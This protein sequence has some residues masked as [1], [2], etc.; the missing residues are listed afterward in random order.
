MRRLLLLAI[1][2][3]AFATMP[4]ANAEGV[5]DT[6]ICASSDNGG[7]S[8]EQRIAACTDLIEGSK[9][10][11]SPEFVAA[12]GSRCAPYWYVDKR[13]LAD[14]PT[15]EPPCLPP[16]PVTPH[17]PTTAPTRACRPNPAPDRCAATGLSANASK[18]RGGEMTVSVSEKSA[19]TLAAP[20]KAGRLSVRAASLS[21]ARTTAADG[22]RRAGSFSIRLA[23]IFRKGGGRSAGNCDA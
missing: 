5:A 1:A 20:V 2:P 3:F 4:H 19:A 17:D 23:R 14:A 9:N 15:H 16:T 7:Y 10:D 8:A 13:R 6:A 22:G 12:L 18:L 11:R 21:S